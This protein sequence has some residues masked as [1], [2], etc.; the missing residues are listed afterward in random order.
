MS[1]IDTKDGMPREAVY[2]TIGGQRIQVGHREDDDCPLCGTTWPVKL[3]KCPG[4][5][6]KH[7]DRWPTA[8][9]QYAARKAQKGD[10]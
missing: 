3:A 4:C 5:G 10:T 6:R 8:Q 9:E 1:H 2:A 7:G